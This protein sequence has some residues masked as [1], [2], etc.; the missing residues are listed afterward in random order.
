MPAGRLLFLSLLIAAGPGSAQ[1][2]AI[3][4]KV[5]TS[6]T[7]IFGDSTAIVADTLPLSAADQEKIREAS[8]SR[9]ANN[10]VVIF[11]SITAGS[12]LRGFGIQDD[13]RGKTQFITYLTAVDTA[14]RVADVDVLTYRESIGGEIAYESFR[15]QFR[16]KTAADRLQPG[17]DIRNISGATISVH[18]ITDGVRRVLATLRILRP[19]LRVMR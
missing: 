10:A 15:K 6:L 3:D 2:Q 9:W 13:V 18:A 12:T 1:R 8:G 16:D 7:R 5:R 4:P 11:R 19:R 14:G 17:R